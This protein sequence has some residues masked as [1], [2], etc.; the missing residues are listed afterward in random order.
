MWFSSLKG[1]E[2]CVCVQDGGLCV[3]WGRMSK[4]Q[5]SAIGRDKTNHSHWT[6][7]YALFGLCGMAV[8]P[9]HPQLCTHSIASSCMLWHTVSWM[10]GKSH[11]YPL[12]LNTLWFVHILVLWSLSSHF[13]NKC[14]GLWWCIC[15]SLFKLFLFKGI[16]TVI[17]SYLIIVRSF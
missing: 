6:D 2:G 1:R 9:Y 4:C 14:F 13:K 16:F 11:F 10:L 5:L 8:E 12:D 15:I 17:T 7:R 3:R